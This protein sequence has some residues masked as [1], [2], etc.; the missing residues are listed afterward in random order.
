MKI[1]RKSPERPFFLI[2]AKV[3]LRE[4]LV[5]VSFGHKG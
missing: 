2:R 5:I 4:T 1:S 3:G